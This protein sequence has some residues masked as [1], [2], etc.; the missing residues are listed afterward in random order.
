MNTNNHQY[1]YKG[2]KKTVSDTGKKDSGTNDHNNSYIHA[3]KRRIQVHNEE[4]NNKPA[5]VLDD[6]CLNQNDYS[7]AL[8]GKVKEFS[9]LT[10]LKIVLA[11]EGKVFWVRAKELSGWLPDF[12][13]DE[14]EDDDSVDGKEGDVEEVSETV[15]EKE[16]D[17]AQKEENFNMT[18][19]GSNSADPFNI[20]DILNKKQKNV[21][22]GPKSNDTT[23]YPPGFTPTINVD[24]QSND[25]GTRKEAEEHLNNNQEEQLDAEVRKPSHINTFNE[26]REESICSGHF[27]R[28]DIPSSGG[29][30]LQV[31]EDLVKVGQ[32]MGYNME[33]CLAQK[34]KKDWVKELCVTNKV[35]FLSLQET[36]MET[37]EE[38]NIKT[39]WGNFSFDYVYSPSVG[40]SG[41]IL[42]VWDPRLFLKANSTISDY[43]VMIRGEWIPNGKKLLI[44]C[45]Y[46][47]Q[48]LSEKK[49]LWDY[50]NL[51]INNWSG[52]VVIMGD[53]NEVR[54]QSER[55]GSIFNVQ[56]ANAFNSFILTTGLE[57]VHLGGCSF[58][59]C[60]KSANKMSKLDRF[61]ISEGLMSS[62]P[63]I[64]ATTLDRYLSDHRPILLRESHVDYGPIPFCFFHYWFEMEGF[65]RFVEKT[66]SEIQVSDSDDML[67]FMKKLKCLK[68][69]IRAWI[70]N[71]K[72]NSNIQK[73]KLKVDLVDIDLLLDKGEGDSDILN[74][75][76]FVSKSLQDIEKLETIEVAQKAKIK[77]AIEGDENSKYYH[78][79]LN[80]RRSQ[81][82][83]RGILVNGTWIDSPRLKLRGQYGT[84]KSPGPNGFSFGFYRSYWNFL[85]KE[86]EQVVRYF[87][88]HGAFPKGDIMK[89][90]MHLKNQGTDLC[91]FIQK[92]IGNGID[93]SFWEEIWR[94]DSAF[95]FLYPRLYALEPCKS[96]TVAEKL[97]HTNLASS[98]RRQPRGGEFFI[99]SVRKT[100][101]ESYLPEVSSKTRWIKIMPI[102][103][104]IHAWKVKMDCLPTRLNISRRVRQVWVKIANWWDVNYTDL[105]SY[106]KWLDW[107]LSLQLHPKHKNLFEGVCYTMWWVC[108][109]VNASAGRLLGAYDLGVATPRAMVHA[110]NKTSGDARCVLIKEES[111]EEVSLCTP[112]EM[113]SKTSKTTKEKVKSLDLKAKVTREQTSNDSNS[114]GGSDEYIDEDEAEA[115]NLMARNLRK[116]FC[117]GNRFSNGGNRFGR[118]R[119][120]GFGNKGGGSSRQKR[121]CYN[122]EEEGHFMGECPK[123]KENKTFFR[124]AWSDSK[125]DSDPQKDATCLMEID[126][127]EVCLKC[128]LLPDDWIVD[129]GC[130][131]HM[132]G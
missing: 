4:E 53:F 122:Y 75:R 99:V 118:G 106:A 44:I 69:K 88:L 112:V 61:L 127:Q 20:Y 71:K 52:E 3:V 12:V 131:K 36:K 11:N 18:K 85:E 132:T 83:V 37:I 57:E 103:I 93:T 116:F 5:I 96:I 72:E 34:A 109:I 79:I 8:M 7:T 15:F 124:G 110:G 23:K 77:W 17:Q 6:S 126:S 41:G 39:C 25:K 42:C 51:V 56:S 43:F 63:N 31:M 119:E 10:N 101:D 107:F 30:M 16:Q 22:E 98:F 94:G 60:H 87:F 49:L 68:E 125:D 54:T 24:S 121:E 28:T 84:N 78:G 70:K 97:G 46:A 123:P 64:S 80:K 29:S 48:E 128:N 102:K 120:K 59:W 62:C 2:E 67:K 14:E 74:K 104:N 105:S 26:D 35:N 89:E 115:F 38:F 82:V 55:F 92:K 50:L 21:N 86:V 113:E 58:T 13:E 111:C 9:S 114:Q 1:P 32:I 33:G 108:P 129:S 66:W 90:T 65:D 47:P 95:K 19:N 45:I 81:L 73:K 27:K 91:G 117:K 100:I 130:T 40:Y 76:V